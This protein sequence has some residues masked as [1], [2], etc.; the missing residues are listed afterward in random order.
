MKSK[1]LLSILAV[2]SAAFLPLA[3]TSQI[4][5]ER[6]VR[7]EKTGP[8]FKYEL[9]AGYGYTGLN[10][11]NQ[12]RNGLQGVNV[13]LTRDWGKYFGLRADGGFYQYP[14]DSTNPGNPTVDMFF[15]GPVFRAPLYKK[16]D[17]FVDALVGME[18]MSGTSSSS[19]LPFVTPSVSMA[20]GG[21][22]GLEYTLD[23]RFSL[24]AEGD[25]ILSTFAAN[26]N[27][28]ACTNGGCSA[29]MTHSSRASFGVVYKF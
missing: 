10:N 17:A 13:T 15:V 29:H 2:G 5:P 3:A 8:V 23:K 25:D 12:S 11:V 22:G 16:L 14:Y 18:Y 20:G 27:Q 6:P 26:V 9:F 21:G 7:A 1:L 24:R 28:A 4:A 19:S